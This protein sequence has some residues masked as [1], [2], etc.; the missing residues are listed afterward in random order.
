L[1]RGFYSAK[2][3][4]LLYKNNDKF[5]ISTRKNIKIYK[6]FIE[7]AKKILPN[8]D[9]NLDYYLPKLDIYSI[10]H[11][12]EWKY[13]DEN[14]YGQIVHNK[15]CE[16][17]MHIYYNQTRGQAERK[18]FLKSIF[19]I[20][21][22]IETNTELSPQEKTL[23]KTYFTINK[24]NDDTK[25]KINLNS[26]AVTEKGNDFGFF[27]LV[28]N[29]DYSPD[30]ILSIYRQKDIIEK[31]FDNCKDRLELKRTEVHSD[32]ALSNKLFLI[33]LSLIFISYIDKKMK[34]HFLYNNKTMDQLLDDLDTIKICYQNFNKHTI[35]EI[36][37][38]QSKLYETLGVTQPS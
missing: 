35:T 16:M 8:N 12:L 5:I 22:K 38:K 7:K 13:V 26:D 2:N 31:V 36:T 33:F 27:I 14:I 37:D 25:E 23:L 24:S 19:T 10:S 17:K 1:D 6:Q 3:I 29:E 4:N 21:E 11:L 34:E 15:T 9:I 30:K 28:T 20:K 32:R 18:E